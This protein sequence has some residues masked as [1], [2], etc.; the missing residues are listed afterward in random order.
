MTIQKIMIIDDSEADQFIARKIIL[1]ALPDVSVLKAHNGQEALNM[2]ASEE[3]QPEVILLDI[4]MPV[5]GGLEFLEE[6]TKHE[7]QAAMVAIL[8]SSE[9]DADLDAT[10]K[11]NIVKICI[12]RPLTADDLQNIQNIYSDMLSQK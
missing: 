12:S 4:N 10:R 1:K 9:L 8:S 5:M 11:H 3:S 7:Q 6:Y 2:L